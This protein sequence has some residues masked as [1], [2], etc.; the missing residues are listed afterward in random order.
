MATLRVLFVICLRNTY[1]IHCKQ[2]CALASTNEQVRTLAHYLHFAKI[3]KPSNLQSIDRLQIHLLTASTSQ[4]VI[5]ISQDLNVDDSEMEAYLQLQQ[6]HYSYLFSH[7]PL[8][9]NFAR[10]ND[11]KLYLPRGTQGGLD[12]I[13]L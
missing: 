3:T 2:P 5:R 6:Q 7:Q 10:G 1:H 8:R 13:I 4:E 11:S 12:S 9:E